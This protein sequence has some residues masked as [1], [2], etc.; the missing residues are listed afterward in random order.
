MLFGFQFFASASRPSEPLP[1][2]FLASSRMGGS[3]IKIAVGVFGLVMAIGDK[4]IFQMRVGEVEKGKGR[5]SD[6]PRDSEGSLKIDSK[7]DET[8][9]HCTRARSNTNLVINKVMEG[10]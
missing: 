6:L 8:F 2:T 4:P 1:R 9:E 5:E 10:D 3:I 7:G